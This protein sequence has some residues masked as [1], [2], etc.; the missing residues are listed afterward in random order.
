MD[1]KKIKKDAEK[2]LIKEAVG[3]VFGAKTYEME[4]AFAQKL[5]QTGSQIKS[6]VSGI[7]SE[8]ESIGTGKWAKSFEKEVKEHARKFI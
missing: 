7:A 2:L 1:A 6:R 8:I 4:S 3:G 5:Q